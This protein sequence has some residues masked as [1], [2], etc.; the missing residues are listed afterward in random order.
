LIDAGIDVVKIAATHGDLGFADA[1]PD[2]PQPWIRRIV[3]IAHGR[4]LRVACHSYGDAGDWAAIHGGVDSIEHLVNVPHPLP[5]AMIQAIVDRGIV[6]CPTL[7]GSAYSVHRFLE[8]PD[9]LIEDPD[10]VAHVP[11]S[12][13]RRLHL[14]LRVMRVP[15]I[16]RLALR[17]QHARRRWQ[18]WYESTL[19]NTAALHDAG[20][21]LVFGTDAPFVFGNFWHSITG[22]VRALRLAGIPPVEI[23]R[24]ATSGAARA[25]GLDR[26]IGSIDVGKRADIV[27]LGGDPVTDIDAI[28]RVSTVIRD[29]R[30]VYRAPQRRTAS[31]MT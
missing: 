30:I 16:T 23:L 15:G 25:I 8:N 21:P 4:G 24:M 17:Q 10:L 1:R 19:R 2:L 9:L 26:S 5:D 14:A 22:E 7:S 29:G 18:R 3:D 13:R 27:L 31:A 12:I 20:V 6:V 28:D 11:S